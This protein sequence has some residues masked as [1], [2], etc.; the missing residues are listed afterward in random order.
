MGNI[1]DDVAEAADYAAELRDKTQQYLHELSRY[2]GVPK[3]DDAFATAVDAEMARRETDDAA[4][5]RQVLN[6]DRE[7]ARESVETLAQELQQ[8]TAEALEA[9]RTVYQNGRLDR[10]TDTYRRTGF[11]AYDPA[12]AVTQIMDDLET[13]AEADAETVPQ[14]GVATGANTLVDGPAVPAPNTPAAEAAAANRTY[15][16]MNE[17]EQEAEFRRQL[18]QDNGRSPLTL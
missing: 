6:Y 8:M 9:A 1:P 12:E 18:E 4:T 10:N 11:E 13:L 5:V 15:L 2:D 14:L 17:A 7:C 3:T 16:D